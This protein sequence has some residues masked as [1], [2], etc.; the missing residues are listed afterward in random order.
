MFALPVYLQTIRVKFINE[1]HRVKIKVTGA[2][3]VHYAYSRN[4]NFDRH[5]SG[6]IK[7]TSITYVCMQHGVFDYDGSNVT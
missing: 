2:E 5:N 6:S 1:G 7:D 3:N 4:V